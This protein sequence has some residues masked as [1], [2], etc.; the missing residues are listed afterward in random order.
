MVYLAFSNAPEIKFVEKQIEAQKISLGQL[1]R[2]W[3]LPTISV[4]FD[5]NYELNRSGPLIPGT[6]EESYAFTM[7]A[8]YP[9]FE[10]GKKHYD[11]KK[12]EADLEALRQQKKLVQELVEQDT[13]TAISKLETSVSS[14]ELSVDSAKSSRKNLDVV[15]EKYLQGIVNVTDLLDAQ[16]QSF[17]ADRNVAIYAYRFLIDLIDFQRSI[18]WFEYEKSQ[19]EKN[20]FIEMIRVSVQ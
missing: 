6:N 1:K 5:Y 3:V 18:S 4:G 9:L 12:G 13:R 7:A 15:Q 19:E 20:N 16:G 8:T 11:I 2:R 14:I 10:G 17:T